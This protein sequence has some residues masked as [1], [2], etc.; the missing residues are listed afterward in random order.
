[1]NCFDGVTWS[2][3]LFKGLTSKSWSTFL[4]DLKIKIEIFQ[5]AHQ[6]SPIL[7][8]LQILLFIICIKLIKKIM[9]IGQHKIYAWDMSEKN[10]S[11]LH[12][13]LQ[14]YLTVTGI[15]VLLKYFLLFKTF[16]VLSMLYKQFILNIIYFKEC[17][18]KSTT[19]IVHASLQ[20]FM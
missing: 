3:W 8:Y 19:V 13:C 14:I 16:P 1:M 18:Y 9:V 17:N 11:R 12:K 15:T 4:P 6:R 20:N 7:T 5:K 10:H 2:K